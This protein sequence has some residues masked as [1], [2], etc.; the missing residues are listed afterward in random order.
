MFGET[1]LTAVAEEQIYVKGKHKKFCV[2]CS[3][4]LRSVDRWLLTDVSGLTLED[5]TDRL[6]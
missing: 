6:S 1:R 4:V 2:L 3:G 5:G